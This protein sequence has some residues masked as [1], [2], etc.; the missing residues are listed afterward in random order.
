MNDPIFEAL[1][2]AVQMSR[3]R[4]NPESDPPTLREALHFV[5][6]QL[7]RTYSPAVAV[8]RELMESTR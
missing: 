8:I 1:C 2:Q 5:A 3:T 6:G 7:T 4:A